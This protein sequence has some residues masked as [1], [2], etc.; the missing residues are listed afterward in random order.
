LTIALSVAL[1]SDPVAPPAEGGAQPKPKAPRSAPKRAGDERKPNIV[2]NRLIVKFKSTGAHALSMSAHRLLE[3]P[4]ERAALPAE[5]APYASLVDLN[6]ESRLKSIR[7]LFVDRKSVNTAQAVTRQAERH[8]AVRKKYAKRSKRAPG[9]PARPLPDLSNYYVLEFEPGIDLEAIRR[10]YLSSPFV[11]SAEFDHYVQTNHA[12][13]DPLFSSSGSWGQSGF[14]LWGLKKIGMESAW[15]TSTGENVVVAVVDSGVDYDHAEIAENIWRNP[16][17]VP[18]NG[19]DDDGNGFIDDVRGWNFVNNTNDPKDDERVGHGTHVSGTIAA[20]GDNGIG[21]IGVAPKAKIMAVKAVAANSVGQLSA[22]AQALVYAIS[23]GADVINCSWNLGVNGARSTPIENAVR[24]GH[25]L[26]VVIVFSAGN[27][28]DLVD[29]QSP[30]N[31]REVITVAAAFPDDTQATFSNWGSR[32]DVAAPG[33]SAKVPPPSLAPGQSILSLRASCVPTPASGTGLVVAERYLRLSGTSQAAPHVAGLAALILSKRTDLTN[34]DV[35]QIIRA[36]A[37]DIDTPGFD[38]RTGYGRINAAK[39]LALPPPPRVRIDSPADG[40]EL[41]ASDGT[42]LVTGAAT[43]D[44]LQQF[45]LFL[46]RLDDLAHPRALGPPQSHPVEG[47]LLSWDVRSLKAGSYLLTLAA[48]DRDGRSYRDAVRV[49]HQ[50]SAATVVTDN[51]AAHTGTSISGSKVVFG[52][53]PITDAGQVRIVLVDL[54]TGLRTLISTFAPGT[55]V[56]WSIGVSGDRVVYS[57]QRPGVETTVQVHDFISGRV[58]QLVRIP[59]GVI[60]LMR[61]L[62]VEIK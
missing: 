48:T 62:S 24:L 25:S 37:D 15:D 46:S 2:P 11:E 26:G 38:F 44:N 12:P 9:G 54:A 41:L 29:L 58:Q 53:A 3:A 47:T 13:N 39:A 10:R 59:E 52:E 34:E 30:A 45:Q 55:V 40:T 17:E 33:G 21:I 14:D 18:D 35:R 31:L 27:D 19:V 5:L 23:N 16:N 50:N 6:R 7:G 22:F 49:F 1:A 32:V 56:G 43:G 60:P 51:S 61:S 57:T 42:V 4:S 8:E 28:S 36:S 20:V